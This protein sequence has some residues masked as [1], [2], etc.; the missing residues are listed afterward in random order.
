MPGLW[1]SQHNGWHFQGVN[2]GIGHSLTGNKFCSKHSLSCSLSLHKSSIHS[3]Y[4]CKDELKW[5]I[6]TRGNRY[7]NSTPLHMSPNKTM[8]W[9]FNN[10]NA[11]YTL[12]NLLTYKCF[13]VNRHKELSHRLLSRESQLLF[14]PG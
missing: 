11:F 4:L 7:M 9:L 2:G 5:E 12:M 13:C 8:W 1:C 10:L 3:S 6:R 14:S